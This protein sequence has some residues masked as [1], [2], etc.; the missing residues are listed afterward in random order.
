MQHP[1]SCL[2][3]HLLH[4]TT[5]QRRLGKTQTSPQIPLR[6]A[7]HETEP[8]CRQP[9]TIRWWV[10]TSHIVHKDCR[11]HTGAMMLLAKGATASFSNKQK[12]NT[13]SFTESELVGIDQALSSILRTQHFIEAQGYSVEQNLLFQENQSTIHLEVNR[14]LSSSKH[15]KHIKCCYFF[16]CDKI[17]DGN[18]EV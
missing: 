11:G 5:Q 12:I 10:N 4:K 13:K 3:P 14:S 17:A 2:L 9:S 15:T 16:I 1:N 6:N 7:P 8:L 18:L